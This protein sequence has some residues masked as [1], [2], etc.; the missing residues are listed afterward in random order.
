VQNGERFFATFPPSPR[1]QSVGRMTAQSRTFANPPLLSLLLVSLVVKR[2]PLL[3]LPSTDIRH[4]RRHNR[5]KLDVGIEREACHMHDRIGYV[6]RIHLGF[7]SNL[8]V[9][10]RHPG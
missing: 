7:R 4:R 3:T 5:H 6:L 10:L 1:L 2:L 8:S 9:R